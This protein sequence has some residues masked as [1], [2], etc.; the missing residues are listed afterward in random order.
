M[1]GHCKPPIIGMFIIHGQSI[2][3]DH[4]PCGLIF[5]KETSYF[6][7]SLIGS[8]DT[9]QQLFELLA[10]FWFIKLY[11][12]ISGKLIDFDLKCSASCIATELASAVFQ[13]K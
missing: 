13:W 6:A 1:H 4:Q 10:S 3:I 11:Y 2:L 9:T 5:H 8:L 7:S 12:L